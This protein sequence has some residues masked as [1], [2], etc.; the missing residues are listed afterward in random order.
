MIVQ[1]IVETIALFMGNLFFLWLFNTLL[2]QILIAW[3]CKRFNFTTMDISAK[4]ALGGAISAS[5]L[6]L[7]WNIITIIPFPI[8]KILVA[9]E[10]FPFIGWMIVPAILLIFNI[11]FG[12]IGK[13]VALSQGCS[14]ESN[15][16]Q[17][18]TKES[19]K[20][21][22][23]PDIDPAY[24]Q[25]RQTHPP[26]RKVCGIN[27]IIKCLPSEAISKGIVERFSSFEENTH[28][29]FDP[30]TIA[31]CYSDPKPPTGLCDNKTYA[32]CNSPRESQQII[33]LR[34]NHTNQI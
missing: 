32:Q 7:I 16:P 21:H 1:S 3:E 14:S 25:C 15:T 10:G 4:N 13:A 19:F 27:N 2:L 5:V 8:T 17:I 6:L 26:N 34:T 29:T 20:G 23:Y 30:E 22:P 33:P 28:H 18:P 9:I 11:S 24:Q 31:Q 12:A